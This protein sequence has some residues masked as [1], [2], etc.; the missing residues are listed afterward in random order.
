MELQ[1]LLYAKCGFLTDTFPI[2]L[3]TT[4]GW[5]SEGNKDDCEQASEQGNQSDAVDNESPKR[6]SGR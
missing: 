6:L 2:K 3:N 1:I 5:R 4:V